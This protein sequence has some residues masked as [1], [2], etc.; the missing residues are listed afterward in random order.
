VLYGQYILDRKLVR[1]RR[2]SVRTLLSVA[3]H[4]VEMRSRAPCACR[5]HSLLGAGVWA[6]PTVP[7][8]RLSSICPNCA[9]EARRHC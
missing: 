3:E 2:G 5:S 1:R 9:T 4:R 6:S 8:E 7:S